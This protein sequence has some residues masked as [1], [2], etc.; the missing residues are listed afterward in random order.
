LTE[1]KVELTEESFIQ[2]TE[3]TRSETKWQGVFAVRR[4]LNRLFVF[5]GPTGAHVIP[6]RAFQQGAEFD[7]FANQAMERWQNSRKR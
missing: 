5:T 1:H 3:L 2:S 7:A 4:G 6:A